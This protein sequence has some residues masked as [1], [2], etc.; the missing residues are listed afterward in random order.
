MWDTPG[1]IISGT[2]GD[3]NFTWLVSLAKWGTPGTIISGICGDSNFTWVIFPCK[4]SVV[5]GAI[6]QGLEYIKNYS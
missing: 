6:K 4:E 2:C 3:S 5:T 1:I